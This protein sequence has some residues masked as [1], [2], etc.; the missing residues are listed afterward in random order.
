MSDLIKA[1]DNETAQKER[2]RIIDLRAM[3]S[4]NNLPHGIY[5]IHG[6]NYL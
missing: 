5:S 6:V 4:K 3:R 1:F 2:R